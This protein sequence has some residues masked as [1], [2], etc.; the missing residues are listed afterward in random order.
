[1]GEAVE[2]RPGMT[3]KALAIALP[4]AIFYAF[5]GCVLGL[6]TD[7]PGTFGTFVIPMVYLVLLFEVLGRLNPRLRFSPQEMAFMFVIFTFLAQ[8]SY[9]FMHAAAHNDPIS[10]TWI[11]VP[12]S[13]YLAF[14]ID[15]LR[16]FWSQSV[17]AVVVPP[18]PLRFEV[19]R[20]L[21]YGVPPGQAAP[22]GTVLGTLFYWGLV[23]TFYSF[24]SMFITFTFGKPWVEE[25][26]LVF[27]IAIPSL[28]LFREAG[29]VSGG[30]NKS[31]L[32]DFSLPSTKVFWAMFFVGVV[33][34][35]NP[36]IAELFPAFPIGAWWGETKLTFPWLAALWPGV[37]AAAVF[38]IPQLAIGLLLPNDVLITCILGWVIFGVLYQGIGVMTGTVPYNPGME[39]VWPW[40]NFPGH[41]MPFPYRLIG[42]NGFALAIAV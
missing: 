18:E 21:L 5:L 33:S 16:D 11:T 15:S 6:Y 2:Y 39:F 1:M 30:G 7:K 27:P 3:T 37:Y 32:F 20:L 19:G 28:Y 34:G 41:W 24:I 13:D 14:T 35:I 4:L 26:R 9:I 42:Q 31:R 8:H 40:E 25:E 36:I 23:Y 38:Y 12:L 17:P 22:L 29:E 10:Y